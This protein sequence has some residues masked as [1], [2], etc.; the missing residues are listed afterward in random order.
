VKPEEG[1][2]RSFMGPPRGPFVLP[3]TYTVKVAVGGKE[4]SQTVLVEDDPRITVTDAERKAWNDAVV[5]A[6]QVWAKADAADKAA[7]SLKKQ[8]DELKAGFEKKKDTPEAVTKG[9]QAL[10]D[11]VDPLAKRLTSDAP[12]GFAGAP[13]DADPEPL[14]PRARMLGFGLSGYVA[15]PTPQQRELIERT[16][17]EVDE[18]AASLKSI[19]QADVPALNK[20]IYEN[21]IGR[22]DA[23]KPL[24]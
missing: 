6:G 10:L 11:K 1:A 15:A 8:L 12:M 17:R 5:E 13:L 19:Q 22:I 3:G 7:K 24:P 21:G 4:A 20:L 9:V 18:V 16:S 14:L 2:E 23:G